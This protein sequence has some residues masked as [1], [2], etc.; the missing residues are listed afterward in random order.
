MDM[1]HCLIQTKIVKKNCVIKF[2]KILKRLNFASE[3]SS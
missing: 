1:K 3:K 2:M